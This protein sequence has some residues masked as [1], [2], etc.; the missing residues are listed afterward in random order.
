MLTYYVSTK[1]NDAFSG[2][3]DAP[4]ATIDRA[5]L[6]VR[7]KIADGLCEPI[8]VLVAEGKYSVESVS[9]D[10]RDSGTKEFPI[11]YRAE[12]GVELCGGA[13]LLPSDFKPLDADEK[14]RLHGDAPDKVLKIDLSPLGITRKDV[15]GICAI[16][17]HG[18]AYKYD[19]AVTSPMS[20][21]LFVNDTRMAL[22]RYPNEGFL[23]TEKAIR[24]G[25]CLEPT[26]KPRLSKEEWE[27]IRNPLGDVSQIDA[28]TSERV[29]GWTH[30]D[31]VWMF[32]YPKYSWADIS[33]PVKRLDPDERTMET[34][35]V[36]RF[37]IRDC[38]PYYFFNVF[39]ELDVPGEWYLDREKCIL[40]IYPPKDFSGAS[41]YLSLSSK[42][43]FDINGADHLTFEG[44]SISATRGCGISSRGNHI[45]IDGCEIKNVADWA[46]VI[47]GN[48]CTVRNSHVHHTGQGGVKIGGG[49]RST[50][51]PSNNRVTNNHIHHIAEIF[52]TY[53]PGIF[54][55][56][57][58]CLAD[59]NLIHDSAHMA[60]YF[61]GN[62]HVMEYNEIH[63]VCKY[64]DDSSAIYAGRDYSTNGNVIRYNYFHDILSSDKSPNVGIFAV[65]CD[66]NLAGC[67][68]FG[69]IMHRCQSA[70][71]LHGGHDIIFS[72]NLIIDSGGK[73]TPAIVFN[74]YLYGEDLIDNSESDHWRYLHA[75]PW[76][77]EIWSKRYPH[78]AEYVSWD[79]MTEQCMPHY[80][81]IEN[82]IIINHGILKLLHFNIYRESYRN[83]MKNN[84]EYADRT[85][86][87][88][89][90]G[91]VLDL[92]NN[93][94]AELLPSFEAIPFEKM[95]M[96]K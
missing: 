13:E 40:Y 55:G 57:V 61:T 35:F 27:K 64:A 28:D 91:D 19:G 7:E 96:L 54:L 52:R 85:F 16:G 21:E 74:K 89:P 24:E 39:E 42:P 65:Y 58:G 72:N 81:E 6:A 37:G 66:D 60:I 34:T 8:T 87:G 23:Y 78:I 48:C 92:R 44:F 84:L 18:T 22:S 1:G 25:E 90:E 77:N 68:I 29:R 75:V 83:V 51:T 41:V 26:G 56:G 82:N 20:C 53:R 95:G 17:S 88:I 71:L 59:H 5:R 93:R 80:C 32:G 49:D 9:F 36:S 67:T 76:Q 30:T 79:E 94:F 33:T 10:E 45:T 12:G 43:I 14:S 73:S 15:G 86:V 2:T 62:E 4:F 63:S 31:D 47:E 50:L 11:T 46:I 70:L 38:A 69:N 3:K